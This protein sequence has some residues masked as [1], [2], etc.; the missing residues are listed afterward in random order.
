MFSILKD[1]ANAMTRRECLQVGACRLLGLSL[2]ALFAHRAAAAPNHVGGRGWGKT[3]SVIL[4][5]FQGGPP[6]QE[7]WDPKP[8][9]P[10]TIRGP[11]K[12]IRT[13][14][15]GIDVGEHQPLLAKCADKYTLVRTVH[16]IPKGQMVHGAAHYQTLTGYPPTE[17]NSAGNI[18]PPKISDHPNIGSHI[19]RL[20][21]PKLGIPAFVQLPRP[22]R[23]ENSFGKGGAAGFLGRAYEPYNLFQDPSAKLDIEDLSLPVGMPVDRFRSRVELR[24]QLEQLQKA[25][26]KQPLDDYYQK[27]ADLVLSGRAKRALDLDEEKPSVRNQYG[28]DAFGQSVLL[29][30][31]LIEAGTRFVQVNWPHGPPGI[32]SW[33]CHNNLSKVVRDLHGPKLDR[34]LSALLLDLHDRGLL[35]DTLV[36]ALGEFGRTPRL[37]VNIS[38]AAGNA[39]DGRDHWPYC[40]TV[41]MA[42]GGLSGGRVHGRSDRTGAAPLAE[43]IHLAELLATVY[44]G[45][46]I[47]PA[48]GVLNHQLQPQRLIEAQPVPALFA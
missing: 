11:F 21:P 6:Q 15:P 13:N 22:L 47:D 24:V 34:A 41:L 28:R 44:H 48:T 31:R 4:I 16:Y 1:A 45:L 30:R 19:I 3:K 43:P 18:G 10:D 46:G 17:T 14:V 38:G 37:G 23:D 5:F 20:K 25:V 7:L 12:T 26:D 42:G 40:Y 36:M 33:D 32:E 29:A 27:A 9:A 2:P 39:P 8:D 35:Q